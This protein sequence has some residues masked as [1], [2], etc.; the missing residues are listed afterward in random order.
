MKAVVL[1]EYGGP[2]KLVYEDVPDPVAGTG[3][4]LVRMTSTSVNPI[5]FKLRSGM[6]KAFWPLELPAILGRDIA[7]IVRAVGEGVEGFKPGDKVMALGTRAYAELT[8]VDAKDVAAVPEKLDLVKAA[9]LPLVTQTG[10]QLISRGTKIEAGQTVLVSGAIGSVGRSAVWTAKKAGAKVIAGVRKSQ[11]KAAES[12]HADQ[13]LA[14]DDSAAMEKLGF[15][16]AVADTVGGAIGQ[17]LIGKVK[18]GGVYASVVGPPANSGMHPTVK[19]EAVMSSPDAETLRA[20]AEDV[21]EERLEIPID[22]MLPLADAGKAQAAAEKGA[23]GKILL[24]A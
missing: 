17:I 8:V 11:L 3:Q 20:M 24:L 10:E 9:A 23:A 22:R 7:G 15:I 5:D 18:Q 21:A 6:M 19:I 4:L 12:L 14:L 16:D 2:D 13:V 1:H